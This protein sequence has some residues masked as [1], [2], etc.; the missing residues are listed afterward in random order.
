MSGVDTHIEFP[1]LLLDL[2]PDGVIDVGDL[3]TLGVPLTSGGAA[4]PAGHTSTPA[5]AVTPSAPAASTPSP[6]GLSAS[7]TA[8]TQGPT[9]GTS[10]ANLHTSSDVSGRS[11]E[12]RTAFSVGPETKT[13]GA[14]GTGTNGATPASATGTRPMGGGTPMMGPMGAMGGPGG[15]SSAG[16]DKQTVSAAGSEASEI[17]HGRHAVGEAVPGGT[18]ARGDGRRSGP[19]A[20]A[21]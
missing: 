6:T 12:Q 13:S 7:A 11:G 2:V 1:G 5:A 8:N 10:A 3:A 16:K 14:T 19:P 17:M 20:D 15:G 18:I 9:S 21:A 4:A